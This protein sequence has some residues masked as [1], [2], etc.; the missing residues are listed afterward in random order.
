MKINNSNALLIRLKTGTACYLA[1]VSGLLVPLYIKSG[2]FHLIEEK[3]FVYLLF[4]LPGLAAAGFLV[5]CP[6]VNNLKKVKLNKETEALLLVCIAVWSVISSCLSPDMMSSFLGMIGWSMGSLMQCAAVGSTICIT[7]WFPARQL[8]MSACNPAKKTSG[9]KPTPAQRAVYA[10]LIVH[11][12]IFLFAVM[13]EAGADLFGFLS[14]LD[15]FYVYSYLSTVGQKNSYA[16]Y[17]CLILPAF[18]GL[19]VES[20]EE[21]RTVVLGVVCG[22]GLLSACLA[23]SDSFYAGLLICALFFLPYMLSEQYRAKRGALLLMMLGGCLLAGG[24]LPIFSDRVSQMRDISAAMLTIPCAAGT[25]AAGGGLYFY[26]AKRMNGGDTGENGKAGSG[27]R[28]LLWVLEVMLLAGMAVGLVYVILHFSDEWGTNR[29]L[30]WRTGWE[31]FLRFPAG[32]KMTGIGPGLLAIPYAVLRVDPGI[33]VVSAHCEPLHVLLTQGVAGLCLYILLWV[34]MGTLWF[35]NRLWRNQRAICFF[36]LAA[37]FG[38]SLFCPLYPVTAALFSVAA[39]VYLQ[40]GSGAPDGGAALH[41]VKH[42]V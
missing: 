28:I 26:A 10:V 30:I 41:T 7:S 17:L 22:L 36:P 34:R 24:T 21:I 2:Y 23:D 38:H 37:Y 29:G 8:Y 13:Q 14:G 6:A 35:R 9:K 3:A 25:A 39:G 20:A 16:G 40:V 11:S 12:I 19:F 33:N 27:S 5:V 18:C 31:Q 4:I 32:R 42:R 1:A 15:Q